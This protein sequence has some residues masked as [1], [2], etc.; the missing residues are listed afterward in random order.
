MSTTNRDGS[1][2]PDQYWKGQEGVAYDY[3]GIPG[4]SLSVSLSTFCF[5]LLICLLLLETLALAE[6]QRGKGIYSVSEHHQ[7]LYY[8][9][10]IEEKEDLE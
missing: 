5:H 8:M 4:L 6:H 2:D 1:E 10:C 3:T 7:G 9:A